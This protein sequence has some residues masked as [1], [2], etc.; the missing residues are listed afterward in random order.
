MAALLAR[1]CKAAAGSSA[2]SA[3]AEPKVRKNAHQIMG[4]NQINQ[5]THILGVQSRPFSADHF[6]LSHLTSPPNPEV[7]RVRQ[8]LDVKGV[9]PC[10]EVAYSSPRR[11]VAS[12]KRVCG[13]ASYHLMPAP[14]AIGVFC[15]RTDRVAGK[16]LQ[17]IPC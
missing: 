6:N 4:P 9:G 8:N 7:K 2:V 16:I 12:A 15:C 10:L 17:D 3:S 13:M 11:D 14:Q 1:K 5:R